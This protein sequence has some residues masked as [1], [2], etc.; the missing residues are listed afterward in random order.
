MTAITYTEAQEQL[1]EWMAASKAVASSQSYSM[2]GRSLTRANA[3][4]ITR[5][6]TFWE[7]KVNGHPDNP[8][9]AKRTR[10]YST[11]SFS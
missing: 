9:R 4:E 7:T 5:M 8:S 1:T 2:N 3:A 6:I 10:R 11:A